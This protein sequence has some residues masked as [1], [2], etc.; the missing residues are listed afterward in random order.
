MILIDKFIS[1]A[2]IES[3]EF[4]DYII[5]ADSSEIIEFLT[6]FNDI[7]NDSSDTSKIQTGF[8]FVANTTLSG[9]PFPCAELLC[10]LENLDKLAR[11]SIL[12]ADTV[13]IQNPF[14][15][16]LEY[17]KIDKQLR[18]SII[19]DL[20]LLHHIR[21]L[22]KAGIFKFA[23]STIHYCN[24]CYKRFQDE[25]LDSFEYN[26]KIIEP[27]IEEY[28]YQN[29]DFNLIRRDS[30]KC[31]EIK[32]TNDLMNHPIIM[33]FI[34]YVPKALS[35]IKIINNSTKLGLD[36][37]KESGLIF[38]IV[39][40]IINNLSVQDF[41]SR[42]YSAHVLTNRE[43]DIKILSLINDN[44]QQADNL[45]YRAEILKQVNHIVPFIE[46]VNLKKLIEL[47][48]KEGEAFQIYRDKL[49]MIVKLKGAEK[50]ELK[51]YYNEE[52][53]PELNKINYTLKNSKK[54]L[55]GN[56]KS[57]ILLAS[58][59]IS[60]SLYSGILPSNLDTIIASVGGFEF[61]KSIGQDLI[62]ILKKPTVRDN[63]L[64]FLWKLQNDNK[65]KI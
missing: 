26:L 49:N 22:L 50:V 34:K 32:G 24:D 11:N 18:L 45:F 52:I 65:I 9:F 5:K 28:I 58:T 59:Y 14:K 29:I 40:D 60:A 15:R 42:Y 62:K 31:V 64:Y 48:N 56:I 36:P 61:S 39:N 53:R 44:Q 30:K 17:D 41:F 21:P 6:L 10:R 3:K 12:Y 55:W 1:N 57:N 19:E 37:I 51:D 27:V 35:K 43:F 16:Y 25:Y 4:Y 23:K 33:S 7:I 46:K 13:F 47:R 54:L 20:I 38:W 63:E 8:N 2:K